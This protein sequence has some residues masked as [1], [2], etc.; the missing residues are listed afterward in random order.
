MTDWM[1]HVE[2]LLPGAMGSVGAMLWVQGTW[3]R[4]LG[5]LAFGTAV[6]YYVGPWVA[7]ETDIPETVA[8]LMV[9]LFGIS[10]VDSLFRAWQD[11]ALSSLVREFIRARLGL[12]KE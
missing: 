12:P 2:K 1:S 11:L 5:L 3:K 8:G 10:I 9:G 7:H 6:T 4:K